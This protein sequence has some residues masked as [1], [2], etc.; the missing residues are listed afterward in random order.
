MKFHYVVIAP[1]VIHWYERLTPLDTINAVTLG[2]F[3]FVKKELS[4]VVENHEAIHVHQWLELG[5]LISLFCMLM[6]KLL[7]LPSWLAAALVFWAFAPGIGPYAVIHGLT[8]AMWYLVTWD[9][10]EAY[11]RIPFER[12]AYVHQRELGYLDKRTPFSWL[13][14]QE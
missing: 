3:V 13:G 4:D 14:P 10:K 7:Q 9:G 12:E 5:I 2:P 6:V 1:N 11:R 8:Y